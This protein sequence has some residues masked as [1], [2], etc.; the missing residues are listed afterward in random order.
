MPSYIYGDN[1]TKQTRPR[2]NP[3]F[4]VEAA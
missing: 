2:F 1:M 4:K 3:E